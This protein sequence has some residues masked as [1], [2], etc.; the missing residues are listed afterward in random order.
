ME[1]SYFKL[2]KINDSRKLY[3]LNAR[4]YPVE[5]CIKFQNL[6]YGGNRSYLYAGL[7]IFFSSSVLEEGYPSPS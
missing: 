2:L 6:A 5:I 1:T 3:T 7:H 4:Y